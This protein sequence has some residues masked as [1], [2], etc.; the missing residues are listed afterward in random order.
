MKSAKYMKKE[1]N[2]V[3]EYKTEKSVLCKK[4]TIGGNAYEWRKFNANK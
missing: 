3:V 1:K 2:S 4:A